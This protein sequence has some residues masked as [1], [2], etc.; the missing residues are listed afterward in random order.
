[1]LLRCSDGAG[2]VLCS[3][4]RCDLTFDK[5][6]DQAT[7]PFHKCEFVGETTFE[8]YA[9]AIVAGHV[10]R[11]DQ[12]YVLADAKVNQLIGPGQDIEV[13]GDR[14]LDLGQFSTEVLDEDLLEASAEPYWLLAD[15]LETLIELLEDSLRHEHSRLKGLLYVGIMRDLAELL[16]YLG[17]ALCA[18]PHVAKQEN[19]QFFGIFYCHV[20][21]VESHA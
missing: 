1:M 3:Q 21:S 20:N 4:F 9:D 18:L 8:Q 17:G 16:K 15:E 5:V 12:R 2:A 19:E 14:R 6:S 7:R 10:G 11:G 13:P